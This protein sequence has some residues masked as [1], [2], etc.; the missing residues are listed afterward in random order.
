[1]IEKDVRRL[2]ELRKNYS[3]RV[4]LDVKNEKYARLLTDREIIIGSPELI[5]FL[6]LCAQLANVLELGR[7]VDKPVE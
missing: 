7:K 3:V 2:V 6:Y 5:E 1:M 4:E